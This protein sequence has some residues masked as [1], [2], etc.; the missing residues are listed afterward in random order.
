[1]RLFLISS[2]GEETRG[3]TLLRGALYKPLPYSSTP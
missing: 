2:W 1:L 3:L